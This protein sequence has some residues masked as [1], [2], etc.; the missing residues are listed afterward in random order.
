MDDAQRTTRD[1]GR[2]RLAIGHLS[3]FELIY[4]DLILHPIPYPDPSRFPYS[5]FRP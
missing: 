3:L 5:K 1:G 4:K 2:K